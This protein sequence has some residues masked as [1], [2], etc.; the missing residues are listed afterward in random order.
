MRLLAVQLEPDGDPD[1]LEERAKEDR[2]CVGHL[3]VR[4]TGDDEDFG[5]QAVGLEDLLGAEEQVR[6]ALFGSQLRARV[7]IRE[8]EFTRKA[9]PMRSKGRMHGGATRLSG[10]GQRPRGSPRGRS[11]RSS[12][13][14]LASKRI[15]LM[16]SNTPET[17]MRPAMGGRRASSPQIRQRRIPDETSI[18]GAASTTLDGLQENT[19]KGFDGGGREG[20]EAHFAVRA[21]CSSR[22]RTTAS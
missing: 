15:C 20:G 9:A 14:A 7:L 21:R 22:D 5:R 19:D 3:V 13:P 17:K 6:G 11:A 8:Q 4:A 16:M 18:A 10:A 1:A 2:L 12:M